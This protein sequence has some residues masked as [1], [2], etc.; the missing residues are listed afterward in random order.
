[1]PQ[2]NHYE[3]PQFLEKFRNPFSQ[4]FEAKSQKRKWQMSGM[5]ERELKMRLP[6]SAFHSV[7]KNK[8]G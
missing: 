6:G 5:G 4:N 2:T 3:Q 7:F 1:L 8:G